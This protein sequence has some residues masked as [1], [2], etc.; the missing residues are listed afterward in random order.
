MVA[1]HV[2]HGAFVAAAESIAVIVALIACDMGMAIGIMIVGIR[3]A[4]AFEIVPGGL[5]A[6]V[7]ALTPHIAKVIGWRVPGT[8]L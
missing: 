6:V 3:V 7:K 8:I 2:G 4:V 1:I 5:N